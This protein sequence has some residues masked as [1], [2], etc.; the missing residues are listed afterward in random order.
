MLTLSLLFTQN[1][2]S[3]TYEQFSQLSIIQTQHTDSS[4]LE[5]PSLLG[6][7]KYHKKNCILIE[8]KAYNFEF[9]K[10]LRTKYYSTAEN[11]ESTN[12]QKKL[13]LYHRVVKTSYPINSKQDESYRKEK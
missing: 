6:L 9:L 5:K 8:D 2:T 13:V 10:L 1:I 3:H 11:K 12:I 4:K 7:W